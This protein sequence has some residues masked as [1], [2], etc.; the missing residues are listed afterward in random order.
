MNVFVRL[1]AVCASAVERA[2]ALAFPSE[3][4]PVQIARKLVAAFESGEAPDG[5]GGRRFTVRLSTSDAVRFE[6]S[7]AYLERQWTAMLVRLAER[8]GHPQ[9]RPVVIVQADSAVASGTVAI[10]V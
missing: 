4:E 1:E 10:A 7:R 2:F 3:L 5:R 9:R 6:A 8:S